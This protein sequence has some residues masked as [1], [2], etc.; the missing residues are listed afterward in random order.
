MLRG[1]RENLAPA[2]ERKRGV[3]KRGTEALDGPSQ[4]LTETLFEP[5]EEFVDP[6]DEP[7]PPVP[8]C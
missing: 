5:D 2:R 3:P 8:S 1:Q 4:T 6:E 7:L